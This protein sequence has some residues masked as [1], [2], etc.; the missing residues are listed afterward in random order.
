MYS[1]GKQYIDQD[2][3]DAV[4]QVMKSDWITQGPT[5]G[6]F[7]NALKKKM[8]AEYAC[9]V[10]NG[11]AALHLIS[12]ACG[13]K[14]GDIVITSPITFLAS[15]NC[16]IYSGATPDFADINAKTYTIDPTLLE[17]K[18]KKYRCDGK[19]IKAIVAVDF[20]GH[21]ADWSA[22]R[23]IADQYDLQ[24]VNDN[25]HALG[26]EYKNDI[27]YAAN[28]ADV[29]A[30]SF[31]PVK[32]VTTGEGGAILTNDSTIYEKV[33]LLRN[34]GMT[35]DPQL[36]EKIDGPWYY[37]M[38]ELGYNYR[39]TDIQ[40]ALGISQLAKLDAFIARRREI[41]KQYN[42]AFSHCDYFFIPTASKYIGHA[43]HLYSLQVKFGELRLDRTELFQKMEADSIRLQVHYIPVHLQPYYRRH[44]G[45]NVRDY[46]V[47]EQ[48][49]SREISLPIYF[50]L[51]DM[52]VQYI[53]DRLKAGIN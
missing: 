52:D 4:I 16:I 47:A 49:Y 20:A 3:I 7:E 46:P 40:C 22:L 45:F 37:E 35:K 8:K 42:A 41:A 29:V 44:Y 48:L 19:S 39:I 14:P 13:W 53:I 32:H 28:Y 15:A 24:L 27:G 18:V 33:R 50:G 34:H 38:I 10:T 17:E 26:A 1:Y 31:H 36:L 23:S 30:L 51:N 9:A 5:V 11:T 6:R 2:D 21:P 43:Y 25:C 12:L